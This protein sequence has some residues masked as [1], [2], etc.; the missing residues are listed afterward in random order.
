MLDLADLQN[1]LQFGQKESLFDTV[2]E[3]P[4]F[5]KALEECDCE[6][7]ILGQEKHR[8]SKELLVKLAASLD[9]MQGND[10]IL[11]KDD[12][13]FSQGH[14][15]AGNDAGQDIKELC[16]TIKLVCFV[17]KRVEAL[18]HGFSDHLASRNQL[19]WSVTGVNCKKSTYLCI[20]LVQDIF[21]IVSLDRLL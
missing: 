14:S 2:R 5:E 19:F 4:V 18:V 10:Y 11:E 3:G 6:C 9:F 12:M 17:N 20:E 1:F 21:E 15:K 16:R 13:L 7:S 8:T